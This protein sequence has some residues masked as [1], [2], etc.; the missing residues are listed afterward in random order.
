MIE[1][2]GGPAFPI[3]PNN[4]NQ[5]DGM[6]L[7]DYFAAHVTAHEI[8]WYAPTTSDGCKKFLGINEQAT[9]DA[10]RY[11]EIIQILKYQIADAMLEARK[12]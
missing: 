9:W 8:E 2:D 4:G 11:V 5:F 12:R 1:S 7:R 6:T 10:A 3:F